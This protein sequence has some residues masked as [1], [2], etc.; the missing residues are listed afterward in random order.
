MSITCNNEEKGKG[1]RKNEDKPSS[2]IKTEAV[3]C[4]ALTRQSPSFTPLSRT[5]RSTS[6]VM[7]IKSMRS[8]MSN[9]SSFR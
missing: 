7:L 8:G 3:M 9:Q 1:K 2:L 4:M 5:Q 6:G